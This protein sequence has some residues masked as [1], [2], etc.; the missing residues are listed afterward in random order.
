MLRQCSLLPKHLDACKLRPLS[1]K[2]RSFRVTFLDFVK[3]VPEGRFD[4]TSRT[5]Q[6]YNVVS[7]A[8]FKKPFRSLSRFWRKVGRF[9]AD[10]TRAFI[11]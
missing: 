9:D 1:R 11:R 10:T 3:A 4:G 2:E 5:N 8:V 7:D 6:G